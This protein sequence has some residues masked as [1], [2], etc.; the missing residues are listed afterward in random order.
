MIA[1][2]NSKSIDAARR[3]GFVCEGRLRE[4]SDNGKDMWIYSML[5]NEC[6]WI[7]G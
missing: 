7:N 2:D 5:K 1:V 3:L 6:R 4:A